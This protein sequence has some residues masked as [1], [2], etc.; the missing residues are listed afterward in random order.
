M[1]LN[2]FLVKAKIA[3]YATGGESEER[4]LE[5][6]S[7]EL[8]Y[9]EEEFRYR[10]RYFGHNPF[11]GEE[12][13][14]KNKKIKWSMNYYGQIVSDIVST[15]EIYT[16]L[17]EALKK[18]TCNLPFRGPKKFHKDDFEYINEVKGDISNF[19]GKETIYFRGK[20]IYVL[21]FHGGY[22]N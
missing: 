10:D 14:W 4:I 12:V 1:K 18:V 17:K 22:V 7:K 15:K 8:T 19:T 21:H 5:E 3:T 11:I 6:G 20:K 16:F 9:Q 13:V 2:H